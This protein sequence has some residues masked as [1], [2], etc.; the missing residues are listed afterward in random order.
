MINQERLVKFAYIDV[1]EK[2]N[3]RGNSEETNV[4]NDLP[5]VLSSIDERVLDKEIRMVN[6]TIFTNMYEYENTVKK[7]K[8]E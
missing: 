1:K 5:N 3:K 6:C 8:Y 7:F 4:G 2:Q